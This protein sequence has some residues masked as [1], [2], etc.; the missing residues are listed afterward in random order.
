MSTSA[1]ATVPMPHQGDVTIECCDCHAPFTFTAGERK[2]YEA[3]R[4]PNLPRRCPECRRKKRLHFSE[5]Q[6]QQDPVLGTVHWFDAV[7]GYGFLILDGKLPGEADV[8]VHYRSLLTSDSFRSLTEGQRVQFQVIQA[9]KGPR[10][11]N[12]RVVGQQE[13]VTP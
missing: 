10:A 1:T 2:F 3:K 7:K 11:A 9:E 13:A 8:F 12:V 4:F 5:E 6:P